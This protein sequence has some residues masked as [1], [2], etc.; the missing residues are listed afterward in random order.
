MWQ[1]D[2]NVQKKWLTDDNYNTCSNDTT[3]SKCFDTSGDTAATYCADLSLG[4]Y[5]DWRLPTDK[6]LEG[7]IDYSRIKPTIDATFQN[8]TSSYYWSS[9]TN[10]GAKDKAWVIGFKYG[11]VNNYTKDHSY[12]IR[13]VRDGQ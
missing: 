4:D 3:S 13:C 7:I 5:T 11:K 10:E 9:T 8:V 6:E 1:D 12:Y 2:T